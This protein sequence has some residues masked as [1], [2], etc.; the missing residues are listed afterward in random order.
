MQVSQYSS[1]SKAA[2]ML[3]VAQ[4]TLSQSI[5]KLESSV[6]AA[7][8]YRSKSGI[9]MT[10]TG[11]VVLQKA[12]RILAD[13]EGL[14]GY[15]TAE[16]TN[17]MET[18]SVRL[19]CHPIVASYFLKNLI[20]KLH[21]HKVIFNP[22][23]IHDHSASIQKLVQDGRCDVAIVVNPIRNPDLV[24]RRICFD[25]VYVWQSKKELK[26][27][28]IIC[29]QKLVQTQNL[30]RKWNHKSP[31]SLHTPHFE[32]IYQLVEAGLGY[33]VLPERTVI[34]YGNN[35]KKV[36]GSPKYSDELCLVHR[37][38]FGKI[39]LEALFCEQVKAAFD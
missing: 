5:K 6:G 1:L 19:G 36:K 35:L 3:G 24:I 23:L 34:H 22:H 9:S 15:G 20:R 7:V 10:P 25:T 16:Y 17:E 8:F 13:L 27:D 32:I 26:F 4:P 12:Q 21:T 37:P 29:D 33:G 14:Q 2:K 28:R 39:D 30:L 38:E 11:H 18:L 31:Q